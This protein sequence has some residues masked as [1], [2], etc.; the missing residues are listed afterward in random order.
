MIFSRRNVPAFWLAALLVVVGAVLLKYQGGGLAL[1][2]FGVMLLQISNCAF[3]LGQLWYRQIAKENLGWNDKQVFPIIY[4]GGAGLCIVASIFS[5]DFA[6][7]SVTPHQGWLLVY[8][9]VIASGLCFFM[10]NRGATQVGAGTLGLM[11]NLKIPLG[12]VVSLVVLK[13]KFN[14]WILLLSL[15]LFMLALLICRHAES[16]QKSTVV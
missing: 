13:E 15:L 6:T 12:V 9:G 8:L 1:D 5:V 16:K 11:N 7:L 2:W 14:L 10:W 3:A 4:A